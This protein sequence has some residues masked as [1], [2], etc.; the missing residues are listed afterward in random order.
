MSK[1]SDRRSRRAAARSGRAASRTPARVPRSRRAPRR[2]PRVQPVGGRRIEELEN[3]RQPSVGRLERQHA[4]ECLLEFRFLAHRQRPRWPVNQ[5]LQPG[6]AGTP[7]SRALPS[8]C[9]GLHPVATPRRKSR[10][11]P[12]SA[13]TRISRPRSLSNTTW[14]A[15]CSSSRHRQKPTN[16]V[17]PEPVGPQ[18]NVWP[19]SRAAAAIRIARVTR[20]QR[21]V[22]RR[23]G[24]RL[25]HR[26]R[27]TPVI[28][29]RAPDGKLCNGASA[30]EVARW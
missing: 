1:P 28:A 11:W 6:C 22:V 29:G 18:M 25:E 8:S 9:S 3:P 21:E 10:Y 23:A 2:E 13:R 4:V 15:P 24:A 5:R 7:G 30:G 16:T 17:L 19:V 12:P 14:V 20:V 26:Q 27:V